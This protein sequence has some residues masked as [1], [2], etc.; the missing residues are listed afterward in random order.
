MRNVFITTIAAMAFAGTAMAQTVSGEV[1]LDVA[2]NAAG[3]YAVTTGFELGVNATGLGTVDLDFS[4]TDGGAVTLD[5][6][7]VGTTIG[8]VG[9]AIGDDNGLMVGAE[10]EHT[11]AAPAMAESVM[12]SYGDAAV[13]VGFTDW[14]ADVTDI[15]NIQGAYTLPAGSLS[16]T[17]A[18]DYNV[19][20]ENTIVGAAVDGIEVASIG[21]GGAATYDV[22]A[23]L[24]GF[25]AVAT[26]YGITAYVNGDSN[27]AFQNVGGEYATNLGGAALTA[28]FNY[29][30]DTED[31]APTAGVSFAF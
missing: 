9:I 27:D 14:T 1:S 7:T 15:S 8:A 19:D 29:N 6:W 21:L 23:E 16:I 4:A 10:G 30:V 12:L 24:F 13:A 25:E 18:F 5:N 28:G 20:S 11:L 3:D 31:F 17:A 26:A 22:D 2:E